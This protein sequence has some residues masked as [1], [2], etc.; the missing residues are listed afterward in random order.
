ML[1]EMKPSKHILSLVGCSLVTVVLGHNDLGNTTLLPSDCPCNR[2]YYKVCTVFKRENIAENVTYYPRRP[3]ISLRIDS[4]WVSEDNPLV[5]QVFK[6]DHTPQQTLF[7]TADFSNNS[8]CMDLVK[9]KDSAVQTA[10]F[11]SIS[12]FRKNAGID[13]PVN[14][15]GKA[16][17][18]IAS[19]E[20]P[21]QPGY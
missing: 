10:K 7:G 16:L 3:S 12:C 13:V 18:D 15:A 1:S 21:D 19:T 5:C 4:P 8:F 6:D 2:K 20:Y 9:H 14:D 17:E 11:D